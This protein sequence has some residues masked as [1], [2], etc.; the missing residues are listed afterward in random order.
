MSYPIKR[1]KRERSQKNVNIGFRKYQNNYVI[2]SL[3]FIGSS[4]STR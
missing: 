4:N 1:K 3:S 2:E